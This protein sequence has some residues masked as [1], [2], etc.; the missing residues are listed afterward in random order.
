[1]NWGHVEF[2]LSIRHPSGGSGYMSLEVGEKSDL[3]KL[4]AGGM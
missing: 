2:V 1:M 3:E 4:G